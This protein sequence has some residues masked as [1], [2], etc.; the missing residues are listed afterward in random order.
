M[1]RQAWTTI[2]LFV[3]PQV[4]ELRQHAHH[5]VQPLVEMGSCSLFCLGWHQTV[6]YPT[7]ASQVARITG[8]SHWQ[9]AL[10]KL[11]FYHH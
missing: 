2:L 3:F 1:L 10:K 4:T 8:V 6:I 11:V 7:S 5:Y 9:L